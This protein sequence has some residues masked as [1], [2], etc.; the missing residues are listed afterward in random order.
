MIYWNNKN[1]KGNFVKSGKRMFDPH[2]ECPKCQK[3]MLYQIGNDKLKCGNCGNVINME[4]MDELKL[5]TSSRRFVKS[6]KMPYIDDEDIDKFEKRLNEGEEVKMKGWTFRK[7][8][9]GRISVI[10][11]DGN[12]LDKDFKSVASFIDWFRY[13]K[14]DSLKSS[15]Q[16]KSS[17][18]GLTPDIICDRIRSR[19]LNLDNKEYNDILNKINTF[20]DAWDTYR[21]SWELF[22]EKYTLADI[23]EMYNEIEHLL[24]DKDRQV[25]ENW[26]HD[27]NEVFYTNKPLSEMSLV[28]GTAGNDIIES[29]EQSH[30]SKQIKSAVDGGWEVRS[31][32]V[33]EALDLFVEY[34]GEEIALEEIAK[35]MGT[36]TLEDNIEWIAQQW[37]FGE[38]LE[39]IEDVWDKYEYAKEVMG[40][41]ELFNN[42]TQAAGYDELAEDLAFIFRQYDFR[43]WDKYDDEIES[44]RKVIKSS[45][46][47]EEVY[48]I[49][50][51]G[52][53][54]YFEDKEKAEEMAA[55]LGVGG[56]YTE[57]DP[58]EIEEL[59]EVGYI[60]NSRKTIKSVK[61]GGDILEGRYYWNNDMELKLLDVYD[62]YALFERKNKFN[63]DYVIA[64]RPEFNGNNVTWQNGSYLDDITRYEAFEEFDMKSGKKDIVKQSHIADINYYKQ[65]VKNVLSN[66]MTED[67][68]LNK[69]AVRNNC[70]KKYAESILNN[71]MD[72][73]KEQLI[74]SDAEIADIMKEFDVDGDLN[75]W[76]EDYMPGS[77]KA[78][79]KGGE[80]VRAAQRILTEYY[81]NGNMIGR[82][83]GNE[84][85]NPAA[86][87]IVEKTNFDGNGE[88][89][90]MLNH[91]V[92]MDDNEYNSWCKRFEVD[93]ADWLRSKG[94][95]FE[96]PNE[97]DISDYA[98]DTDKEFF[99]NKFYVEDSFGNQYWF[100]KEEDEFVCTEIQFAENSTY[101][102][103]DVLK[104]GDEFTSEIDKTEDYGT[105]E[106]DGFIYDWEASGTQDEKGNYSEWKI[107]RVTISDQLFEN[108]DTF[109]FDKVDDYNIFDINGNEL[110]E[111]DLLSL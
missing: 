39:D 60:G 59:Y 6:G 4:E 108:D 99:I 97:D 63:D 9:T 91:L 41:S 32:D 86:R 101:S 85:V 105:F 23:E 87:Y 17:L 111:N 24:E 56:V 42:L 75:S 44:S 81:D 70:N 49:V 107:V 98:E 28:Y 48:Y 55:E 51:N 77:G 30:K 12:L 43:E 57:T 52:A 47:P 106:K 11:P 96:Q 80:L 21:K 92:Q 102:E 83:L 71:W 58:E 13:W 26:L 104:D 50:I 33:P 95:L 67:E 14:K 38:E 65:L 3:P 15:R 66:R 34:N 2:M 69:I 5:Y 82:G 89:E 36:D 76:A 20:E 18:D 78:N 7:D 88:I 110:K 72:K 16:I 19:D 103:D 25:I 37:G 45:N 93:F 46:L 94:D 1:Y 40:V 90:D 35:A 29:S 79:T 54:Q 31:S 62:D 10:D 53:K 8:D 64:Y 73:Y 68:A 100:D 61:F 109:D 22:S 74:K 84:T 27:I